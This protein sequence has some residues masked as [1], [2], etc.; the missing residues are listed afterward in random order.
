MSYDKGINLKI[1]TNILKNKKVFGA[2]YPADVTF[3]IIILIVFFILIMHFY[4]K[5]NLQS[6]KADW[7]NQR[8]LPN[9]IPFAGFINKSA[10][11]SVF[12]YTKE[13]MTGC[14]QNIV[15]AAFEYMLMPFTYLLSNLSDITSALNDVVSGIQDML[16]YLRE[17]LEK[18]ISTITSI[19]FN[20]GL[21]LSQ[22]FTV[23]KVMFQQGEAIFTVILYVFIGVIITVMSSF[24]AMMTAFFI[25]IVFQVVV[26]TAYF[27]RATIKEWIGTTLE[28]M[29][30]IWLASFWLA[31]PGA[32]AESAG[33][34]MVIWGIFT[35]IFGFIPALIT[36]IFQIITYIILQTIATNA[37]GMTFLDIDWP[38][39]SSCFDKN[40]LIELQNKKHVKISD[41]K[42]ND[43]LADNSRVTAK[44]TLLKRDVP[45][46][47]L[48]DIIVSGNHSIYHTKLGWI[49]VDEHPESIPLVNYDER[50]IYCLNTDSKTIRIN[51][52]IFSDWDELDDNDLEKIGKKCPDLPSEF[53]NKDINQY[54]DNGL[55]GST[56]IKLQTDDKKI[57]D[58][59]PGDILETGDIITG[60]VTI[61]SKNKKLSKYVFENT[62]IEGFNIKFKN[63]SL[64]VKLLSTQK[65]LQLYHIITNSGY[66]NINNIK[67]KHYNAAIE[68]YLE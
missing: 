26:V 9:I 41:V 61:D 40:T 5:N 24:S 31:V 67:V 68:D 43:I 58:L 22:I 14:I 53:R 19:L 34:P 66:L 27:W 62:T 60:V 29:G 30:A 59:M 1:I 32:A 8:C 42:I 7:P 57:S 16:T 6:I 3:T 54:I 13:N 37:F 36:F 39:W 11:E 38:S 52:M 4:I 35:F 56:L 10:N 18:I 20:V 64:G 2:T 63:E 25:M 23:A 28:S 17:A 15:T 51:N 49:R 33:I 55:V 12:D 45:I 65:E 48:N 46:F 50:Y 47:T 44:M 21:A